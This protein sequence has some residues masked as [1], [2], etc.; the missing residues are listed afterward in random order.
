[1]LSQTRF[2][3]HSPSPTPP[4][5]RFV[6]IEGKARFFN[7]L[8]NLRAQ[9]AFQLH[10]RG[11]SPRDWGLWHERRRQR[12]QL[13]ADGRVG[14]L[15]YCSC[16]GHKRLLGEINLKNRK[17]H[18]CCWAQPKVEF[19]FCVKPVTWDS[20]A[21]TA[22]TGHPPRRQS[23]QNRPGDWHWDTVNAILNLLSDIPH[24]APSI[25]V[26]FRS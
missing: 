8:F 21:L 24:G 17:R 25:L 4:Q 20:R 16:L 22:A 5:P 6:G 19:V 1:M 10:A 11:D 26:K 13:D 15:E 3:L 2:S 18:L 12:R 23:F 7:H 9:T 14:N